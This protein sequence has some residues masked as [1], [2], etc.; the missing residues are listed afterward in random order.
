MKALEDSGLFLQFRCGLK[1]IND[2]SYH[3]MIVPI[4]YILLEKEKINENIKDVLNILEVWYW[5]SLFS[6][7]YRDNMNKRCLIDI[8]LLYRTIIEKKYSFFEK[9]FLHRYK[10]RFFNFKDY[11]DEDTLINNNDVPSSIKNSLKQYMLSKCPKDFIDKDIRLNSWKS[12]INIEYH[13]IIPLGSDLST[14]ISESNKNLRDNKDHILN[15]PINLAPIL[16]DSNN[17]LSNKAIERYIK[18]LSGLAIEHHF[19]PDTL[20]NQIEKEYD[21]E[22][23]YRDFLKERLSK[24]KVN[25]ENEFV[26]L[27]S[28]IDIKYQ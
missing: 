20:L 5:F 14:T 1:T 6:G 9:E 21:S 28:N 18:L 26:S 7:T 22:K 2:L 24:I 4:S 23:F 17:K 19:I 3:L 15:S 10:D 11:S 27:L 25:V 16:K 13:H 8:E 12:D